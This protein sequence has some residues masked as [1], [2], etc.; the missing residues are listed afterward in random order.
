ME[1]PEPEIVSA[2]NGS[3]GHVV[4][5]DNGQDCANGDDDLAPPVSCD[6]PTDATT[7]LL[8]EVKEEELSNLD[9][10]SA[11]KRKRK[12]Q[13]QQQQKIDDLD[14]QIASNQHFEPPAAIILSD[15]IV[16]AALK[17]GRDRG[18]LGKITDI[19]ACFHFAPITNANC[20]L[21]NFKTFLKQ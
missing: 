20:F 15:D 13:Q 3:N 14:L 12:L 19:D 11:I 21:N 4:V 5:M 18:Q 17:A 6:T 2:R 9:L 1:R 7:E 10:I 16:E 8:D